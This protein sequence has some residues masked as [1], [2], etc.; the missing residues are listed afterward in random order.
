MKL[1]LLFV[2][3]IL[4]SFLSKAQSSYQ[5]GLLPSIN[6]NKKLPYD[7]SLNF[8]AESRQELKSGFFNM[9]NDFN[10][11]YELTDFSVITAKKIAINKSLTIGYLIR[12]RGDNVINRSIQQFIIT[13]N[14]SSFKL[15]HRLSTDQT[16]E[17]GEETEFRVRYRLSSEIALNG[18]SVDPKEF[19][20]KINNEYLNSWQGGDYDFEIRIIPFLGYEFSDSKKLELGLDYRMDSFINDSSRNRFWIGINWFQ[21]I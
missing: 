14:Y 18:Q 7:F 4:S 17:K 2:L 5:I 1:I 21:S 6:I 19:Y 3:L 20:L 13:K 9:P 12:I 15:A 10:Y 8:K 11:E 16:F